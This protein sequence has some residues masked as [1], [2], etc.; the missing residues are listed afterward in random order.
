MSKHESNIQLNDGHQ[1]PVLGIGTLDRQNRDKIPNAVAAAIKYGYRQIDTATSY[2]TEPHVAEGI[3]RS[4]LKRSELFITSKLWL[5]QYGFDKAIKGFELSLKHLKTD[6]LDLYLLHWPVP[7]D[8]AATVEAFRALIQLKSEGR[9]RSIGVANFSQKHL[10]DLI[11]RTGVMPSVN[12]IELHPFFIQKPMRDFHSKL[13]IVT[14]AWSP[15]GNSV[16]L[17]SK[18]EEKRDPLT[19][20]TIIA[21]SQKHKKTPAQIILR[22]HIQ[23]GLSAIPKSIQEERIKANIGIFDFSLDSQDMAQIDAMD[24]GKRSGPDP[25]QVNANT[26]QFKIAE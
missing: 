12:Q 17:F 20:S 2:Q 6:Y 19:H 4:G 23:H 26:Y 24:T 14:Q 25:E 7:S 11:D 8:F 13:G 21:L 5:T 3:S 1:M 18:E 15:I 22:W 16:R 9:L 10:Q